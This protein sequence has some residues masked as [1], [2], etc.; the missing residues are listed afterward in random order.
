MPKGEPPINSKIGQQC[1]V[2][3]RRDAL[4]TAANLP[5]SPQTGEINGASVH[6]YGKL[7][8]VIGEWIV[9]GDDKA[10]YVIPTHAILFLKFDGQAAAK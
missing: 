8:R 5:V 2:Q 1:E 10:E 9:L 7:K 6:I 3:F 4:G